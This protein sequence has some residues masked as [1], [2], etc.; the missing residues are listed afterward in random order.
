MIVATNRRYMCSALFAVCFSVAWAGGGTTQGCEPEELHWTAQQWF[1]HWKAG[2]R[3]VAQAYEKAAQ[4]ENQRRE[5]VQAQ[6]RVVERRKDAFG[7]PMYVVYGPR[8]Y[9][10]T[11]CYQG[12]R[13]VSSFEPRP[14]DYTFRTSPQTAVA[15]VAAPSVPA[16]S[17]LVLQAGASFSYARSAMNVSPGAAAPSVWRA[18]RGNSN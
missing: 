8:A 11:P 10:G 14:T 13:E 9:A 16:R 4:L 15:A 3:A 17:D 5:R 18:V 7:D 1:A 6:V 2:Q 12:P